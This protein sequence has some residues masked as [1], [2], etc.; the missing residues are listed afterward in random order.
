MIPTYTYGFTDP[1]ISVAPQ[2]IVLA[3]YYAVDGEPTLWNVVSFILIGCCVWTIPSVRLLLLIT[4]LRTS[5][6]AR[7]W[8]MFGIAVL[9]L[10]LLGLFV[11]TMQPVGTFANW[12]A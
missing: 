10:I 8:D 6:H 4:V 1:R 7:C 2:R 3:Q 5:I 9:I 11:G 12:L